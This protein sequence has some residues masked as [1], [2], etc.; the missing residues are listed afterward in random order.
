MFLCS[1]LL[2]AMKAG[3]GNEVHFSFS[4]NRLP[5]LGHC[6]ILSFGSGIFERLLLCR[7]HTAFIKFS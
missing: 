5:R 3:A 6:L 4:E 7:F 2:L 1:E